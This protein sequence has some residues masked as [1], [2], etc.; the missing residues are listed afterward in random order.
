MSNY[1]HKALIAAINAATADNKVLLTD[2][3]N[4][5]T[6]ISKNKSKMSTGTIT[7]KLPDTCEKESTGGRGVYGKTYVDYPAVVMVAG[8]KEFN[9]FYT[10]V[11]LEGT[12]LKSITIESLCGDLGVNVSGDNVKDIRFLMIAA[13]DKNIW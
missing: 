11:L 2:L 6:N 7:K 12:D 9:Y 3:C 5:M 13:I 10:K 8:D 1:K 4:L